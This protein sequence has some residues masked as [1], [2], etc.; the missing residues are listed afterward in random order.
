MAFMRRD[1]NLTLLILIIVSIV[2]FAGFSAYYQ[3]TFK[4]VSL[5]YKNKLEQLGKVTTELT[6]QKQKL[7]ETYS[8]RVKAEEDK[9]TL[10]SRY[11]DASQENDQFKKDNEDLRA[12]VKTTK[13]QLG[14]KTAELDATKGLLAQVQVSLSK[15][16]S[17][18][19]SL[20]TKVSGLQD[21][22]SRICA[23]LTAAGGSD[24]KC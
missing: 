8:M 22:V 13:S 21:D 4:G 6:T 10:D 23:K 24:S 17:E 5:E 15:A 20:K 7:N 18:V 11:R 19:S 9:K 16:T 1:V 2:I 14:E 12:E 3:T